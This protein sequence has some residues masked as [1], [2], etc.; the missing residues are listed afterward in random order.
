MNKRFLTTSE[1]TEFRKLFKGTDEEFKQFCSECGFY[2]LDFS[3]INIPLACEVLKAEHKPY[4]PTFDKIINNYQEWIGTPLEGKFAK[5]IYNY[6]PYVSTRYGDTWITN[7]VF[8]KRLE[9]MLRPVKEREFHKCYDRNSIG[10]YVPDLPQ[11]SQNGTHYIYV[12]S[13]TMGDYGIR[14]WVS[15][16]CTKGLTLTPVRKALTPK[17]KVGKFYQVT[18]DKV[19]QFDKRMNEYGYMSYT[20]RKYLYSIKEINEETYIQKGLL[21]LR[22]RY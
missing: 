19:V 20:K 13:K 3:C 9:E 8:S 16:D 15:E 10:G 1:M 6:K 7:E 14:Y 5:I 22:N 11:L 12:H 4:N 21:T 2:T 17:L 18:L